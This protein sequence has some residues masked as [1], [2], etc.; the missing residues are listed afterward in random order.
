MNSMF[1]RTLKALL[2][3]AVVGVVVACGS[4]TTVDP[5]KPTRVIGLGDAYNDTGA[6]GS[7]PATVRGTDQTITTV[8]AQVA[9]LYGAPTVESRASSTYASTADLLAQA[10]QLGSLSDTADLV[11]ITAGTQEF[12]GGTD[13]TGANYLATLKSVLDTLKGKGAKHIVIMEVV[14][15]S[16][17]NVGYLDP[18][19][20]NTTVKAGLSAYTDV[21]R[22]GNINRPSAYF[23]GWVTSGVTTPYCPNPAA[24][25]GCLATD[26]VGADVSTYFLADNLHPTPAG[27][28]WLGT[29]LYNGTGGGWR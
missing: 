20:F 27:N 14:D 6:T 8:V 25:T 7:T 18:I 17:M 2:A 26:R 4:S 11:V 12:I 23:P 16:L 28:Q 10:N 19:N 5:F 21:A 22:Y 1:S 13:P 24:L 29:Q 9:A 3:V 15:L